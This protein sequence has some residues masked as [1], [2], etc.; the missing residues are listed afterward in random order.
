MLPPWWPCGLTPWPVQYCQNGL[1][2]VR[3]FGSLQL[4]ISW[5]ILS[6]HGFSS[7]IADCLIDA[8]LVSQRGY[9]YGGHDSGDKA[10]DE[11]V[12]A[13]QQMV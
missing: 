8:V 3:T 6:A 7:G 5:H 10:I 12:H 1:L 2:S 4:Y 13:E 9:D 11:G